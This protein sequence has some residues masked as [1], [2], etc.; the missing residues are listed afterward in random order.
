VLF[1]LLAASAL[2]GIVGAIFAV[3]I[4]AIVAA[5]SRY[6]RETLVFERWRRV[7]ISEAAFEEGETVPAGAVA[8]GE[9][10]TD[11]RDSVGEK[12]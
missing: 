9:K 11:L 6:L 12:G 5:A 7:P 8:P 2:Y 4:V 1:A 3:P 10:P